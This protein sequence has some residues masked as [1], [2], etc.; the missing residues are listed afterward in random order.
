MKIKIEENK[1]EQQV[2]LHFLFRLKFVIISK[3]CDY[4]LEKYEASLRDPTRFYF[5]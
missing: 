2:E 3:A 1:L 4:A 5:I